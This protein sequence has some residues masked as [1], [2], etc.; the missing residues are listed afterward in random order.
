MAKSYKEDSRY[1]KYLTL[2]PIRLNSLTKAKSYNHWTIED[3]IGLA[4]GALE[5]GRHLG[6]A[7]QV[8]SSWISAKSGVP[9]KH[10]AGVIEKINETY[11]EKLT[12][13][14]SVEVLYEIVISHIKRQSEKK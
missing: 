4:G 10:W 13:E 12:V 1:G 2:D 9:V 8:V 5:L 11:G 14:V 7:N 3:L 6:V